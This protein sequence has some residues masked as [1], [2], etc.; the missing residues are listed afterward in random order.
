[1]SKKWTPKYLKQ[2]QTILSKHS[3]YANALEEAGEKKSAIERAFAR[4]GLKHPTTYLQTEDVPTRPVV[5]KKKAL[6][7]PTKGNSDLYTMVIFNDV[8][9]PN[10]NEKACQNVMN[11]IRHENP[12]HVVINGDLMDCYWL[13]SFPKSP[14]VPDFQAELDMTIEFLSDLRHVAPNARID[15]LEGNHEERLKRRLKEM[16]AFHS[17][18]VMNLPELLFLEDFDIKYYDYKKPL[19]M[20]GNTLSIIHGHRISKHSA[21]SA[22]AHLLDD[23][24]MNVIMG[25]THRIGLYCKTGHIGKRRALENG[26][27]FDK[28][29]LDY[30]T[31]PNWQNG[32]CVVYLKKS[33]PDFIHITPIEMTDEGSFIWEGRIFGED[34]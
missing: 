12:D 28:S 3:V 19:N 18:R 7:N 1:M 8:H 16:V 33:D 34:C 14:G 17:L 26:G 9:I 13:S 20:H 15:Y 31:N 5:K 21:Y 22:K 24:F 23:D 30:T 32:F 4:H 6:K 27:L 2:T 29:K 10:H 25:H 11:F